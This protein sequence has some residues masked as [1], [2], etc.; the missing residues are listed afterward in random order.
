[1]EPQTNS[2]HVVGEVIQQ[3]EAKTIG[4]GARMC[5]VKICNTYG[6]NKGKPLRT[7]KALTAW[8]DLADFCESG[9]S[10]GDIVE[11]FCR[12]YSSKSGDRWYDNYDILN[13]GEIK[14]ASDVRKTDGPEQVSDD[15][16]PF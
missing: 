1:M 5:R 16:L 11:F 10:E 8:R 4:S 7:T 13:I 12:V 3:P 14:K 2:W 6:E 15:D 9:I